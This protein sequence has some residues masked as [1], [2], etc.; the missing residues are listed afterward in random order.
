MLS[1]IKTKTIVEK[2][3]ANIAAW[4]QHIFLY[5]FI[6]ARRHKPHGLHGGEAIVDVRWQGLMGNAASGYVRPM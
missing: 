4:I 3:T 2:D 6:S 1:N 5:E